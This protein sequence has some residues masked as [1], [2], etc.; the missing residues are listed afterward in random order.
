MEARLIKNSQ[1]EKFMQELAGP[2]DPMVL[3]WLPLQINGAQGEIQS[4]QLP[5]RLFSPSDRCQKLS[6]HFLLHFTIDMG[7]YD[8]HAKYQGVFP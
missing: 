2:E 8:H 6:H 4:T 3:S 7:S 1:K 5:G